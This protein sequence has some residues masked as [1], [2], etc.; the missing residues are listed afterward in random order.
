MLL[1]NNISL[2]FDKVRHNIFTSIVFTY[3]IVNNIT[4]FQKI[5][6]YNGKL[7]KPYLIAK[8]T[9]TFTFASLIVNY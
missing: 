5:Q 9:L 6:C 8:G 2:F 4:N 3:S 7:R 1:T